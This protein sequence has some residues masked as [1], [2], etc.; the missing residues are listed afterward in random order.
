[1]TSPFSKPLPRATFDPRPAPPAFIPG[2]AALLA[3]AL[4]GDPKRRD[5]PSRG[6]AGLALGTTAQNGGAHE[7]GHER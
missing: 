3:P 5:V 7:L 2:V 4:R 6:S 1:M